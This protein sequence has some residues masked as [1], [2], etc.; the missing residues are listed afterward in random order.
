MP[1]ERARPEQF[2]ERDLPGRGDV[3]VLDAAKLDE[4]LDERPRQHEPAEPQ[5]GRQRLARR[6]GV[7]DVLGI[8]RLE[9]ADGLPVVPELG[10]VV[11]LDQEAT[12]RPRPGDCRAAALLVQDGAARE[13]VGRAENR[14]HGAGRGEEIGSSTAPVDRKRHDDET[15]GRGGVAVQPQAGILHRDPL[16]APRPQESGEQRQRVAEPGAHDD[17]LGIDHRTARPGQVVGE[18]LAQLAPPARVAVAEAL[19][20]R[21]AQAAAE[22]AGPR[23]VRERG[24][25]GQAGVEAEPRRPHARRRTHPR[26]WQCGDRRDPG[27]RP[28]AGLQVTLGLELRIRLDDGAARDAEVGREHAGRGKPRRGGEPSVADRRPQRALE[29]TAPRAGCVER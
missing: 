21:A 17:E 6:P 1:L 19:R 5:A 2:R 29:R 23:R 16:G 8:E 9:R 7:D 3:D 22:S 18:R 14:G 28:A 12:R 26:R 15:R 4:G 20:R 24:Q 13:L 25:V 10:V 11:V 27:P